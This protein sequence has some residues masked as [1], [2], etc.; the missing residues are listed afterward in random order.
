M[1]LNFGSYA[2]IIYEYVSQIKKY[3]LIELLLSAAYDEGEKGSIEKL[4]KEER[5]RYFNCARS[6]HI[7]IQRDYT[8]G[9][10]SRNVNMYF[11]NKIFPKLDEY[12]LDEVLMKLC[13]LIKNDDTIE[14]KDSLLNLINENKIDEY[15]N[16]QGIITFLSETFIYA[17]QQE[18]D[19]KKYEVSYEAAGHKTIDTSMVEALSF[20]KQNETS[21]PNI[22]KEGQN[23]NINLLDP[24]HQYKQILQ[25]KQQSI[26]HRGNGVRLGN[27]KKWVEAIPEF[28]KAIE[29][30][31]NDVSCRRGLAWAYWCIEELEI[32]IALY[33]IALEWE[34]GD[35]EALKFRDSCLDQLQEKI[36]MGTGNM[37][38]FN[39]DEST[40]SIISHYKQKYGQKLVD[41]NNKKSDTDAINKS[42][43]PQ[44]YFTTSEASSDFHDAIRYYKQSNF[45]Q[46]L[47]YLNRAIDSGDHYAM[48]F[49]GYMYYFGNYCEQNNLKA[50]ELWTKAISIFQVKEKPFAER[51]SLGIRTWMEIHLGN[52]YFC[53]G[54]VIT[55]N[56]SHARE[57]YASAASTGNPVALKMLGEIYRDGLGL[58][59]SNYEEA[60]RCYTKA[61]RAGDADERFANAKRWTDAVVEAQYQ[62]AL[63]YREGPGVIKNNDRA[64]EWFN[65]AASNGHLEAKVELE[66]LQAFE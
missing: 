14:Q 43:K 18:N 53:E 57:Y 51:S 20:D 64:L 34:P 50:I 47:Y 29:L 58:V 65:C 26:I 39:K 62:L 60:L 36:D 27:S 16:K 7:E 37:N 48:G 10:T 44:V 49:L 12:R 23:E 35:P 6:I 1:R 63:L 46:A 59:E 17:V 4:S 66:L 19:K 11:E 8:R 31:P 32:A 21:A 52:I 41:E 28:E 9:K 54:K 40:A 42:G 22:V 3:D 15:K 24:I 55:S 13:A 33:D 2:K 61:A 25:N 56:Y 5:S 30:N 45:E 38:Q